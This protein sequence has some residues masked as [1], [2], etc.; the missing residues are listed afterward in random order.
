MKR[1]D[2]S[3]CRP[4]DSRS[5]VESLCAQDDVVKGLSQFLSTRN[6]Q[7]QL[8]IPKGVLPAFLVEAYTAAEA[9]NAQ[10]A[11][12]LLD[13]EAL[14]RLGQL[15]A[16]DQAH[17]DLIRLMAALVLQKSGRP[18]EAEMWYKSISDW[19]EHLFV[20]SEL[21]HVCEITGR[22]S[23]AAGYRKL[24]MEVDPEHPGILSSF[25]VDLMLGGNLEGGVELLR[26]ALRKDPD[27]SVIHSNIL[28]YQHYLPRTNRQKLFEEHR[29]WGRLH[30]PASLAR[31]E[32]DRVP[33]PER[34]IR[35]GY[36]SPDFRKHSIAY[37]F[38]AF[39]SGRNRR[40]IEVYGYGNVIRQD[41]MTERLKRQFDRYRNVRGVSDHDVARLIEEDKIDI[42]VE[43][44]GHTADN[45]LLVMAHK[46]APIQVDCWGLN[47][48]GMI[49]IDYRITESILDPPELQKYYVEES[50]HLPGGFICYTPPECAP[51]VAPLPAEHNGHVTFGS[52]NGCLK[53][54]SHILS[55]W[56]LVLKAIPDSHLLMKFSGGADKGMREMFIGR[57]NELGVSPDRVK[58]YGWVPSVEHLE[59]YGQVDIVLDTYPFNGCITTLEGLWMGVPPISLVGAD[60]LLARS[61]LSILTRLGMESF[62]A[63]TPESFVARATSLAQNLPALAKIR[64]SLRQRMMASTL[65]D[66]KQFAAQIE[67]AYREM[68][69]R[70]CASRNP[71]G[72][73]D[74]LEF[75]EGSSSLDKD[76]TT[77]STA[78]LCE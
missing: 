48:S 5:K 8:K 2:K 32:H 10:Q 20:L 60:S 70:W 23:D 30:A 69:R 57:L 61:G 74:K 18:Q 13:K 31:T 65:C 42:L 76:Q 4:A 46:P 71:G 78:N 41:E 62:A 68:W 45:R 22:L 66:T 67:A 73:K 14:D 58:M 38:E 72:T 77:V 54:N 39:L 28:W 24:A 11:R 40:D 75:Q 16:D 21:G 25:A 7:M 43:L 52:F 64:A 56:A 50:I 29:E 44:G 36:I 33:D 17:V 47:T 1:S 51:P 15:A 6:G 3:M 12:D 27:N 35:I 59:L 9:G 26:K 53:I 19:Q 55:L 63:S 37:N 49:Q 34:R